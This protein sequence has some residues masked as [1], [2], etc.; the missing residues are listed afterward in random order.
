MISP[1]VESSE[2]VPAGQKP[3]PDLPGYRR[4]LRRIIRAYDSTLVRVYCV[5]R[6]QIINLN[7]LHIL[8]LALRGKTRVLEV[9]CGFG[10]FGCYFSARDPR[11]VWHGL[12]LNS[13]RIEMARTAA[14]RLGLRNTRF[15]VADA[16]E[17][18][19]L[20]ETYDAV[21]MMDLLHHI[22]DESKRQLLDL[23][24][25]RLAPGG[26]LIIKDVTRRPAWKLFFTWLLDVAMTRG[27]EMWYW[28]PAQFRNAI[29][30]GFEMEAY[31]ISDWLPYPH[32]VYLVSAPMTSP[33]AELTGKSL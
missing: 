13:G 32:I 1:L 9:G 25:S 24:L 18:L 8:S 17:H 22:P 5:I 7:M 29:D 10:L 27:F 33:S 20:D 31:P 28:T 2:V 4:L 23:V 3:V 6:F 11:V 19:E 30:P 12:D 14:E 26:V 16:R 21:V 15:S